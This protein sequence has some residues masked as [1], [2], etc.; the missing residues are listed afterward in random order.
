MYKLV[1]ALYLSAKW[2]LREFLDRESI[3]RLPSGVDLHSAQHYDDNGHDQSQKTTGVDDDV[4]V[5]GLHG[6]QS[7]CCFLLCRNRG[8]FFE[9]KEFITSVSDKSIILIKKKNQ[10]NQAY[11]SNL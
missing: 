7:I 6:V 9:I 1:H 8:T 2:E 5:F 10:E 3:K 11:K 4:S